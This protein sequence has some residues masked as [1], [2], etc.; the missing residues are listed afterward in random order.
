[1]NIDHVINP[2][3]TICPFFCN[4]SFVPLME[5]E[6]DYVKLL[7]EATCL[8]TFYQTGFYLIPIIPLM[9]N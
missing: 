7:H 5:D 2:P 4:L 6:V 1:M 9:S 3:K 8:L